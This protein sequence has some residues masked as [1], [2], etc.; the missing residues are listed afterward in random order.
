M[1]PIDFLRQ[2]AFASPDAPAAVDGDS[3]CTFRELV[4][5]SDA[6]A[7]GLQALTCK[8][9]PTVALLGPNSV[10]MLVA[11]MAVHAGG[12]I[13][14]PLNGRN[15]K[16]ELDAQIVRV[17]PD[18]LVV[19]REYLDKFTHG[20]RPIVVIDAEAGD[21][22]AMA[23]LERCHQGQ[24]AVWDAA[25]HDVNGIKFTGGSSGV[26][27][28]V[29][30]SFRVVNTVISSVLFAF[31]L[32]EKDRYLCAAPMT[33]GAGAMLLP[34]LAKG[35]CAV[36][37]SDVSA[38]SLLDLMQRERIT[39]TWIPPT[40]LYKLID[41]QKMRPR[42]LPAL[43]HL[44]WGGAT[45]AP[46]R[47]EEAQ[48]LF[49]PVVET[50]FGQTEA[51]LIL[52]AARGREVLDEKR[53]TSVGR[54]SPYSE[55]AILDPEGKRLGPNE[56]GEICARG[57]LLLSGYFEMPEETAKTVRDGWLHTGDI[58]LLDED[59][60]LYVKDRIRDVVITGGFN[61]YPSDVEAALSLHPAV[62]EVVVYGVPDAHWGERVEAALELRPG[63]AATQE[64]L[65][66]FCK[67]RVGSVKT[68]KKLR[69]VEALPRSPVGKVLRRDAKAAALAEET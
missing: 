18:V 55:I 30:Q 5:R 68:P 10:Q 1:F 21:P 14:V 24:R 60:F 22:R 34:T 41:E 38:A 65:I 11:L 49:G 12:S 63:H 8:E 42:D 54:V 37:T 69:I 28:G 44:I 62:S 64:E 56:A 25:L 43:A 59:G 6:L 20:T 52:S 15:A 27:K 61:V 48:R 40:L 51:S 66:A 17:R 9:R 67:E 46:A 13:L 23:Q 16:P 36:L 31:E 35:G 33:H 2:A 29:M 19:Q 39:T 53:R 26:P 50:A 3:R 47:I 4:A 32:T 57:D 7:A 58:G 45:A